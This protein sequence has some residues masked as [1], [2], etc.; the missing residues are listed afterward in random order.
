MIRAGVLSG[1]M[2]LSL[3]GLVAAQ[4]AITDAPRTLEIF[5]PATGYADLADPDRFGT[6]AQPLP[7][8]LGLALAVR[9]F[10]NTCFA[11]ERGESLEAAMPPGFAAYETNAYLFGTEPTGE[12]ASLTLSATGDIDVDE[13]EGYVTFRISPG[14]SGI[15]C[16]VE[17]RL[18]TL[19]EPDRQLGMARYV[20]AWLPYELSLIR[21]E[22]PILSMEPGVSGTAEWD[23][24][25]GDRWCPLTVNYFFDDGLMTLATRLN[26]SEIEGSIR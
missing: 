17:W 16:L 23:R 10:K 19:P 2:T 22:R 8:E 26:I 4:G 24:P 18:A 6:P 11:L 12:S 5:V 9:T 13:T 21:V 3:S 20:E 7:H 15:R 25:C 14:E 1:F